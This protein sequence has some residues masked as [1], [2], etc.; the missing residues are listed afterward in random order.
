MPEGWERSAAPSAV[1]EADVPEAGV[2]D[3][4]LVRLANSGDAS[5]FERIYLRHRDWVVRLAW[6]F[7]RNREDA[8]DV[9]QDAFA[10]LF[11]K[12]PGFEL[13]AK[14]T[15][16]LYP[17][18]RNLALERARKRRRTVG[19]DEAGPSEPEAPPVPDSADA[20][21]GR[22]RLAEAL[23]KLNEGERE[24]VHLR[25]TE[26]MKLGEIARALAVPLGTVKSR[27]H[28]ALSRLRKALKE[29]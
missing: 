16:F 19:I 24:V 12:F 26:D 5:A 7:A 28:S 29:P 8:L 14:M 9:L 27:L 20:G 3:E 15:T 1:C 18:V 4:E 17:V 25:F 6:R 23:R 22:A 10:Y 21:E 13:R 11:G 2:S